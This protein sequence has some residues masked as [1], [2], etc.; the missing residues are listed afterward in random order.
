MCSGCGLTWGWTCINCTFAFQQ[1][2]S[3][4]QC[5]FAKSFKQNDSCYTSRVKQ[6]CMNRSRKRVCIDL[7]WGIRHRFLHAAVSVATQ[8]AAH[9]ALS[10]EV[11]DFEEEKSLVERCGRPWHRNCAGRMWYDNLFRGPSPAPQRTAK[12]R[13][14]R[15][16]EPQCQ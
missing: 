3:K 15:R 4:M 11:R 2:F 7:G 12:P 10:V 13:V 5:C 9:T 14:D 1:F 8:S 16:S 6:L